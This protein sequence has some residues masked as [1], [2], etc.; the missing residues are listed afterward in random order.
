[1]SYH[2][3]FLFFFTIF[4]AEQTIPLSDSPAKE[5]SSSNETASFTEKD[6]NVNDDSLSI[7][8]YEC[9]RVVSPNPVT[10]IDLTKREVLFE[11][12]KSS[13]QFSHIH[14]STLTVVI[15][16]IVMK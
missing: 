15:C 13:F 10:G 9:L 8:P 3:S 16:T 11:L 7:H 1:M 14:H 4:P 12:K 2:P 5:L 6:K